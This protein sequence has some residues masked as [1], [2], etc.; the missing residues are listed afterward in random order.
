MEAF[1]RTK[2]K[3]WHCKELN[4]MDPSCNKQINTAENTHF[5]HEALL[6]E[7]YLLDPRHS[8]HH[9]MKYR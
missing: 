6:L 3:G 8:N 2:A 1:W 7:Q 9:T 4:I 5:L